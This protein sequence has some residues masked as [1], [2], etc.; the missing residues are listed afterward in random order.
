MPTP[1]GNLTTSDIWKQ[2]QEN[3]PPAEE[4]KEDES[5]DNQTDTVQEA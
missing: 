2:E 4:T 5:T 1:N 3:N